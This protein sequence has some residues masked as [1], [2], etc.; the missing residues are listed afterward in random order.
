MSFSFGWIIHEASTWLAGLGGRYPGHPHS[1]AGQ[2]CVSPA[3]Q[4]PPSFQ[5][6]NSQR[7]MGKTFRGDEGFVL[8]F[9]RSN[10]RFFC[11]CRPILS[12]SWQSGSVCCHL[13][14]SAIQGPFTLTPW[15]VFRGRRNLKS[16]SDNECRT[17]HE[18]QQQMMMV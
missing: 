4:A 13:V 6:S 14:A 18:Q 7:L 5:S 3:A 17:R 8:D 16:D 11:N 1:F 15:A 12:F 10:C 2:A 9:C